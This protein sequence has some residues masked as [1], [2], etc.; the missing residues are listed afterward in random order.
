MGV[1]AE[2][3]DEVLGGFMQHGVMR[4]LPGP[5]LVLLRRRQLAEEQQIRHLKIGAMLGQGLDVVA[6]IAQDA[7]V[8]VDKSDALLQEAVF[9]NAG[10]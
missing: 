1:V 6:A 2:A 8:A 10:S 3:I 9:M 7:F 5:V 4:D